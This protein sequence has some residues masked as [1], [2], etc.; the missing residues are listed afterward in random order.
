MGVARAVTV[1][2]AAP[3]RVPGAIVRRRVGL[4][5]AGPVRAV[6]MGRAVVILVLPLVVSVPSIAAL[7][8]LTGA[9]RAPVL[10]AL[11]TIAGRRGGTHAFGV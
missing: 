7:V 11:A 9:L 3:G 4:G 8:G 10:A 2:V 1:R 5:R 6:V